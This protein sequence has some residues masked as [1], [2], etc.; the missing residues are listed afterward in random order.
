[1]FQSVI[2]TL[3][4]FLEPPPDS[5]PGDY[6]YYFTS[7]AMYLYEF[8]GHAAFIPIF[9]MLGARV[10]FFYNLFAIIMDALCLTLNT[11]GRRGLGFAISIT[12]V[13]LHTILCTVAF[14]WAS[15]FH[16]YILCLAVFV[17]IAPWTKTVKVFCVSAMMAAYIG[18]H[19]Y[20]LS[21]MPVY[22]LTPKLLEGANIINIVVN[23]I[24]LSFFT[25]YIV[26]AVGKAEE[27]LKKSRETLKAILAASPIGISHVVNREI[28]WANEVFSRITGYAPHRLIGSNVSLFFPNLLS[29]G[30]IDERLY[31]NG[32]Q[33]AIDIPST[34]LVRQDGTS[35]DCMVQVRPVAS[36]HSDQ[37][38]VVVVMDISPLTAAEK[39]RQELEIRVQRGKKMEAIGLLA[40]GV[41]HDLNNV[42][43]GIVS[44]P[45]LLLLD[46]PPQSPLA[47]PINTIQKAGEKASAIVQDLLSLAR[48]GVTTKA[49]V[50]LN[51]I[52]EEYLKSPE[53]EKLASDH[54]GVTIETVMDSHLMNTCAV[55]VHLANVVMNLVINAM[56]AMPGG[57]TV[58]IAT[59]NRYLDRPLKKGYDQVAEGDYAV[60]SVK[61]TG[62]GL[63]AEDLDRIFEPFYTKKVMGRSGTGLGLAV[64][65][66]TVR[67]CNGYIDVT[68]RLGAGSLFTLYFPVT[69]NAIAEQAAGFDIQSLLG[70][71]ES[72]LVVDDVAEQR[73]IAAGML[74]RLGYTVFCVSSGE[75]AV[76][77]VRETAID[78]VLLDMIMDPGL[79]GLET[80]RRI[81]DHCPRQRAV[82]AS[83]FAETER[84]RKAQGLGAGP[85]VKKPYTLGQ[86]AAVV[87]QTLV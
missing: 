58:R 86:L 21:A 18:L 75:D 53:L 44:Y 66:T 60:L 48:R 9:W 49:V 69:R 56:E 68:S 77:F 11:R 52:V 19:V 10:V 51:P 35:L 28:I 46:L 7:N 26:V 59:E 34:K 67:D 5:T 36:G 80:Y 42:L 13:S 57:G 31:R 3:R 8:F 81:L 12:T 64:V 84:V 17:F 83:G 82:I 33:A 40:G 79:D 20:L 39:A 1:M 4:G 71:G 72:V 61:D 27:D 37:G 2:T 23:F 85:Y 78:L 54:E 45:E 55:P 25:H 47:G 22:P 74:K 62:V 41:A 15:G 38:A 16:Y 76:D 6:R 63:S 73:E 30:D 50:N 24:T 14:G 65:W 70:K 87:R 32:A 43:S 29:L